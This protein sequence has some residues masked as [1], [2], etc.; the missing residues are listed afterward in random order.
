MIVSGIHTKINIPNINTG[1]FGTESS[2]FCKE[3][4]NILLYAK[5][6]GFTIPQKYVLEAINTAIRQWIE[7]G[8]W[9]KRDYLYNFK[10]PS[11]HLKWDHP[12]Q[13]VCGDSGGFCNINYINPFNYELTPTIVSTGRIRFISKLGW[14]S[15]PSLGAGGHVGYLATGFLNS[16]NAINLTRNS[17]HFVVYRSDQQTINLAAMMIRAA[18]GTGGGAVRTHIQFQASN[19]GVNYASYQNTTS[20]YLDS[21]TVAMWLMNRVIST[22]L[23]LYK[24]GLNVDTKTVSTNGFTNI[25]HTIN[26]PGQINYKMTCGMAGAGGG[27]T[28]R[29]ILDDYKIWNEYQNKL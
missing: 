4:M 8:V 3:L 2:A 12:D 21:D 28:E 14:Y 13:N 27:L 22:Q 16:T 6:R 23:K 15:Q 26:D 1:S 25:E 7:A 9:Q 18:V 17:N 11:K 5:V 24:N 19:A 20:S 10:V 29:Q